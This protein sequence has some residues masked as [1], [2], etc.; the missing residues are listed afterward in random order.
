MQR[1]LSLSNST[2]NEGDLS[3]NN[4]TLDGTSHSL[5]NMSDEEN[6]DQIETLKNEINRL[7]AELDAA[8]NEIDN[9]SIV[10]T[11]LTQTIYD[12]NIKHELVKKA[13]RKLS[14]DGN[15]GTPNGKNCLK[16]STPLNCQKKQ[17]NIS[18]TNTISKTNK[19]SVIDTNSQISETNKEDPSSSPNKISGDDGSDKNMSKPIKKNKMCILSTNNVLEPLPLIE[20]IFSEHFNYC[21]YMYP[22]S[23]TKHII[24]NIDKKL[25]QYTFEDYC[26][27]FIGENDI[28]GDVNYISVINDIKE[29]LRKIVH[30]NIVLCL[31]IY[32]TGSPI[33]NYKVEMFN[34]LMDLDMQNNN[35]AYIFDCNRDLTIDMFSYKTGRVNRQGL[36]LNPIIKINSKENIVAES[37]LRR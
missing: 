18:S 7:K 21:R 23:T 30:T 9:L 32:I 22:N 37:G 8:H 16:I 12:M 29:S 28:R 5:P 24:K 20:N 13:S 31:P 2:L 1:T 6:C 3:C 17:K 33:Y 27:I 15:K 36:V 4:M 34:N 11:E 26:L 35:Y 19:R 25:D 10:N 14:I